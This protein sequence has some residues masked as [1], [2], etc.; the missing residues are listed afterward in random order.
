VLDHCI[1]AHRS[2]EPGHAVLLAGL[3][4]SPLLDLGLRLGEGSGAAL[5]MPLLRAASRLLAEMATFESAAVDGP[6]AAI[7]VGPLGAA[8]DVA[9]DRSAD[10]GTDSAADPGT[11]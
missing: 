4:V 10:R 1:V 9:P 8:A 2:A 6:R 5:A 11:D 7:A 3:G